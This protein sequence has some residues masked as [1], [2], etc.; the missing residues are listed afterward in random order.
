MEKIGFFFDT[1]ALIEIIHG[2][3]NYAKYRNTKII[4][5][6]MNL[7][8][9]HY[10]ILCIYGNEYAETA[11]QKFLK[12]VVEIPDEVIKKAN[13]FKYLNK[14]RKLS[15]IDCVGYVLA[16]VHNVKFLTGDKEFKDMPNVEFVK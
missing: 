9:L 10:R 16:K 8:E 15:Y 3:S 1:Y 5:S 12:F 13:K 11:Y 2:N 7:M 4:T 14:K 6:K